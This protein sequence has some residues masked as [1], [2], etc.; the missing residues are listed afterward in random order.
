MSKLIEGR[1]ECP[2]YIEEGD[3]FIACEGVLKD[4]E[5]LHKFTSN[6][7]K[8]NYEES[9]CCTSGGRKC[10]HYRNLSI[11]YERGLKS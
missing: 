9:V 5:C 2:F 1:I 3:G 11:L 7:L 10:S 4:T 8:R 6:F